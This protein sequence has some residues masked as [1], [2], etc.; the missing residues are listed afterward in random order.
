M[1]RGGERL[2]EVLGRKEE[3]ELPRFEEEAFQI[4]ASGTGGG[5]VGGG[6]GGEGVLDRI[7][8]RGAIQQHTMRNLIG[9][10]RIVGH[11]ELRC[12][13]VRFCADLSCLMVICVVMV[14]PCFL[15]LLCFVHA[16]DG[17]RLGSK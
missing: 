6:I 8:P 1:S 7:V 11:G 2:E 10:V 3:E 13:D 12:S 16:L 9:S 5:E 15:R 4:E 17:T 14:L